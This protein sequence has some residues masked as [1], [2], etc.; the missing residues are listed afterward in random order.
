MRLACAAVVLASCAARPH[1]ETRAT[2]DEAMRRLDRLEQ[3]QRELAERVEDGTGPTAD[4]DGQGAA[5]E[6]DATR[7][8]LD[9]VQRRLDRIE[10]LLAAGP[11]PARPAR[12]DPTVVYAVPIDGDPVKGTRKAKITIVMAAEFACPFCA[13]VRATLAEIERLYGEDVRLVF[14]HY[15]VHPQQATLP[16]LAACAAGRQGKFWEMEAAI[17]DA[18]WEMVDGQPTRRIEALERDSLGRL[19]AKLGLDTGQFEGDLDG[20]KCQDDLEGDQG[21]LGHVGVSGT[22]AF[23]VNGRYLA[24]AQPLSAFKRLIDEELLKAREAVRKGTRAEDYYESIVR[25]GKT[26]L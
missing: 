21:L 13:K 11:R 3:G 19:A 9:E 12:P 8:E 25:A 18:A 6:A 10:A 4:D 14:K 22:P 20:D 24:G 7:D 2:L 26:S 23:F 15:I 17:F 16:A 1:Q 5:R